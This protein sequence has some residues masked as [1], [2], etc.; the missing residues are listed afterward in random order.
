[1]SP[2]RFLT[3]HIRLKN[4]FLLGGLLAAAVISILIA[5]AILA[6]RQTTSDFQRFVVIG[7]ESRIDLQMIAQ[8]ADIQRQTLI[9][10]YEGH[11]SA[12][13]QVEVLHKD[14]L[15]QA[16]IML[17]AGQPA[18]R[19]I[20]TI[21]RQRLENYY[22]AFLLVKK[23]REAQRVLIK[24][25]FR[26]SASNAESLIREMS[27]QS[28]RQISLQLELQESLN[29]LLLVE[30]HLFR[31]LD[32]FDGQNLTV[33]RA[34]LDRARKQLARI[35][36]PRLD[37][38]ML[39]QA[40]DQLGLYQQNL[41][42]V[43]QRT[44]GY[45]YLVN[46][47]MPAEASEIL[48]QSRKLAGIVNSQMAD[49]EK[50]IFSNIKLT[51]GRLLYAG[52]GLLTALLLIF[53]VIGQ[54]ISR[55]IVRLAETFGRL[56]RGES[57]AHI[58][59]YQLA[60]EIGQLTQAAEAFRD[61]N[62]QTQGLL[63]NTLQL[64]EALTRS[65]SALE[66]S[67]REISDLNATL[68]EKVEQR[69]AE[70]I[71]ASAAKSQFL[72]QMSHELRTPMNAVIGF[73]QL[74]ERESLSEDQMMQVRQIRDSG[75]TLLG[76][77][78]D[79][80][81]FSKIEAGQLQIDP[82]PFE[83]PPLLVHVEELL[84]KAATDKG[85]VLAVKQPS[86]PLSR[87]M[88]DRLRLEQILLNLV[89]NAIKFTEQGRVDLEVRRLAEDEQSV[90]LRFDI[91]D[92]GIGIDEDAL[93]RL[94]QPFVQAD[95]SINRRFG[96]TGLGLVISRRLVNLMGG[97]L[98]VV[99]EP[100]QGSV[101]WFELSLERAPSAAEVPV[102]TDAGLSTV[103]LPR[104]SGLRVLA[105]DDSQI[106]R[107]LVER[108]LQLEGAHVT[109]ASHGQQALEIL[110]A[111]PSNFDAVL[112]DVQ[113]P[114]MDG[115]SAT[116]A[117]RSDPDLAHLPVFALSAGVLAEEREAALDAGVNDFLGKPMDLDQ[118]NRLLEPFRSSFH[119]G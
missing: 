119:T 28:Q 19:P 113:M 20:A 68:E 79:I 95:A 67:N 100:G 42:E 9:Y 17:R 87:L 52:L 115:L 13:N 84:R 6:F 4:R 94:F 110:K 43:I 108:A 85:I 30:K 90:G 2:I 50:S 75:N 60:D 15:Q 63:N 104:L 80:L 3:D 38:A 37:P 71:A 62:D 10:T 77:I 11:P 76:I 59:R 25:R 41:T 106:N 107:M 93:T 21:I 34:S 36:G 47:V 112:M 32:S 26:D 102:I 72:A 31:Y 55:P 78:S 81:D 18:I 105:V 86:E 73:A 14:L 35:S 57:S 82:Q 99:S 117:I 74:L 54:S 116:R 51:N 109:L 45:L 39:R 64:A 22:D 83:L 98:Q 33:A 114:I 118:L 8:M 58:P 56:A 61:K 16:D 89:G 97:E 40:R 23:Q 27:G 24:T 88:G 66:D 103:S 29:A 46:V 48:Y 12:A 70:L 7:Q 49:T 91:R 111:Q 44:R 5:L 101:F 1:M 96:G 65:K 53:F 69:T 92:T